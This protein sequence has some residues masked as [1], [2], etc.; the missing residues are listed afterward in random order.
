MKASTISTDLYRLATM[1][2]ANFCRWLESRLYRASRDGEKSA[3]A[4]AM[5][6]KRK[7]ERLLT[8]STVW[9]TGS[10]PQRVCESLSKKLGAHFR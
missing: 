1:R 10:M 5:E 7:A 2:L 6:V 4:A 9:I 8:K 3:E